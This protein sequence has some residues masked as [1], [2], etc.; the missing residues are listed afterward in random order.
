MNLEYNACPLRAKLLEIGI[1]GSPYQALQLV[2]VLNT[3]I[4][5]VFG[6][7][8]LERILSENKERSTQLSIDTQN[9]GWIHSRGVIQQLS[10][11]F[12]NLVLVL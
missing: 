3:V 9:A 7:F 1:F 8:G 5:E 2:L 11:K 10:L 4:P 6:G 12:L